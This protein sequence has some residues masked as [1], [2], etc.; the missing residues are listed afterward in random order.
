MAKVEYQRHNYN[1]KSNKLKAKI[2]EF[3]YLD[4]KS[5]VPIST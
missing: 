2:S 5:T 3:T 4:V 1:R